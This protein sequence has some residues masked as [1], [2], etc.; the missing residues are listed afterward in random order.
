[1]SESPLLSMKNITK[2]FFA[3]TALD[4]VSLSLHNNEILGLLGENGAGKSTLMKILS[5]LYSSDTYDG[6]IEINEER[7]IF[8]NTHDSEKAGI[9]MIYQEINLE[10]DLSI[11]ENIYLGRLPGKAGVINWN[12]IKS[13]AEEILK[14]LE[15][16]IDANVRVRD[17]NTSFQQIVCIAR[18]L[19]RKPKILILDEPTSP[20]TESE[21]ENLKK[22]LKNL[23]SR[24][25]SCIYIT[26]KLDEVFSLCDR[27]AVLR[28]S[29]LVS[30]YKSGD[31]DQGKIIEDMIGRK[32]ENMYPSANKN[33][34]NEILRVENMTIA[35]PY[36]DNKNIIEDV[37]FTLK[38][39]EIL[40]L[41]GLVGSGRS[42][43]VKAIFGAIAYKKG[44]IFLKGNLLNI[45]NPQDAI[46]AGIGLLTEDRNVDG[47]IKV[48]NIKEN[49]SLCILRD[50][51]KFQLI[52][53]KKEINKV[54]SFF[55]K[56]KI[57]APTINTSITSLSGGNQ[58]KVILSKWLLTNLK[59]LILDEPT[60][61][62]DV[63]A[64]FEIYKIMLDLASQGISIIMISSE[65]P[66]LY[67][68]C[69]RFIVL[70]KGKI[71]AVF[72]K[73]DATEELILH[74]A[75]GF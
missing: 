46:K 55:D 16:K 2:K 7:K 43:L 45:K 63:G 25:I 36:T 53:N 42:E 1:M 27:L 69:D 38:E 19:V 50:I 68:M 8:N 75:A 13:D 41:A 21:T 66:E 15:L 51:S 62:I 73:K 58:Q 29:K 49:M 18:A 54:T 65:L 12:K 20:L 34:G 70:S 39:G 6:V 32:L 35:H 56:I 23:K 44:E 40:G 28:D 10:L 14:Q 3:I 24:G 67:A 72:N 61:G 26:H 57:K 4:N 59:I 71:M 17:L 5:G 31:F 9:A 11:A 64:K 74:A 48:M 30:I 33:I 47:Y 52:N 60:R 37:S 22:I